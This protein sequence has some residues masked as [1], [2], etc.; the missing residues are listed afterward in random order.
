MDR[1]LQ[2]TIGFSALLMLIASAGWVVAGLRSK[3]TRFS[4]FRLR[5]LGITTFFMG[6]LEAALGIYSIVT[7]GR[8]PNDVTYLVTAINFLTGGLLFFIAS[9]RK[10]ST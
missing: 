7:E 8:N 3:Y 2:P 6:V 9:L 4:S 1:V 5:T 10:Q